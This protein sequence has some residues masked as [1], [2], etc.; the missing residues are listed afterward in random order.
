MN[1]GSHNILEMYIYI[2]LEIPFYSTFNTFFY[3]RLYIHQNISHISIILTTTFFFI[4][5]TRI[6]DY[7]FWGKKLEMRSFI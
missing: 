2:L 3:W 1:I 6:L 7:D 4:Y 5:A